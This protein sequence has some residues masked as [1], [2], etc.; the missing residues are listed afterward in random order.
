MATAPEKKRST[1]FSPA[2]LDV[3][4]QAYGEYEH[5]FKKKATQLQRLK[6][7]SSLGENSC[8]SQ[9]VSLSNVISAISFS[10][11]KVRDYS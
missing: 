1:Y 9:C 11:E 4:L 8:S 2:E 6:R 7:D 5:I 3:L 10:L